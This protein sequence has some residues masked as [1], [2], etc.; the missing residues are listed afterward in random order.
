MEHVMKEEIEIATT[1]EQAF[2]EQVAGQKKKLYSIAY[3]Y[4]RNEVDSLE[5]LQEATFRAWIKRKSLKNPA[6]FAPWLTRILINCCN[7]ELKRKKRNS[8]SEAVRS[9]DG[10]MEM[11]SD[12]RL[13][14]EQALDGVKAKYRQVLVLKYYKDMTLTE[15][16]EVL[17]KPEGTVKTWLNKGLKQLRDKMKRK[18]DL[19]YG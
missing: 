5:V 4:L 17:N 15:I 7:D 10:I 14:M 2:Y 9:D 16:A 12:R 6:R 8:I 3:S 11:R 19:F 13:D 1:D 18:G